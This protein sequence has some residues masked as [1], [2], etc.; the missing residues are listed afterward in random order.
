M[1]EEREKRAHAYPAHKASRSA[2]ECSETKATRSG[3]WFRWE[4]R[5]LAVGRLQGHPRRLWIASVIHLLIGLLMMTRSAATRI[6][7]HLHGASGQ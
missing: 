1:G 3:A 2:A 7:S 4:R 6:H 5:H